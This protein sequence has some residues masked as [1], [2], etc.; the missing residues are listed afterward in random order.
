MG[1]THFHDFLNI[2]LTIK[3]LKI[4]YLYNAQNCLTHKIKY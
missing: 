4:K 1:Q 2:Y 3:E